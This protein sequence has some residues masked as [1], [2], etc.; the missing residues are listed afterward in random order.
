MALV[1]LV[2]RLPLM[3][4]SVVDFIIVL[5]ALFGGGSVGETTHRVSTR[6][7]RL[8]A[9][10]P[11]DR[12]NYFRAIQRLYRTRSAL[13]HGGTEEL[14]ENKQLAD[15]LESLG[16]RVDRD[17][18]Q[19]R[20]YGEFRSPPH[21]C[22]QRCRKASHSCPS[23]DRRSRSWATGGRRNYR[24]NRSRRSRWPGTTTPGCHDVSLSSSGS[25]EAERAASVSHAEMRSATRSAHATAASAV[26]RSG[27]NSAS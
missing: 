11:A 18:A 17:K 4:E 13:V 25:S 16:E 14:R 22:P 23:A 20:Y 15:A 2:V 1:L 7:A 21:R 24:H 26:S 9:S 5:D 3:E 8:L 6:T 12:L 27:Q 19:F 10:K